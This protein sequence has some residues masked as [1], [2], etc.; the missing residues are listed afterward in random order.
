MESYQT[1]NQTQSVKVTILVPLWFPTIFIVTFKVS[2]DH[3]GKPITN[4]SDISSLVASL[5]RRVLSAADDR[6]RDVN[7]PSV[8][9]TYYIQLT[10]DQM[11]WEA[12]R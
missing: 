2:V 10:T 11:E 3:H 1:T 12:V 9:H 5:L 4:Q 8:A 7:F 6:S